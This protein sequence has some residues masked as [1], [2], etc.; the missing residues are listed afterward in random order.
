MINKKFSF[1]LGCKFKAD[2]I[3]KE[4]FNK[5][6]NGLTGNLDKLFYPFNTNCWEK[7]S[8]T[9]GGLEGWW[10]YEQYAYWLDGYVKCAYFSNNKK[11][12]KKAKTLIDNALKVVSDNGF[13]GAKEL[14][15]QG[16]GNQWVHAVFFRAVLFLY[17]ITKDK[18]Y[19]NK[20]TNHYLSNTNDYSNWR[21]TV[22]VENMINCFA[23]TGDERLLNLAISAYEKHSL[24]ES[25]I[26]TK[27]SDFNKTSPIKL[28]AVTYNEI[29]KIPILLYSATGDE[30]YLN[31][32]LNGLKRI[33]DNH[34][35]PI[36]IHSGA[37]SF[38]GTSSLSAVET[39]DITDHCLTLYTVAKITG[40]TKYLD[41]I[42]RIMYNVAPS[43]MD[44]DFKTLQYFSSMNQV[45][46]TH[47][48]NHTG[49][50]T[51]TPRMS[52][53]SDH[54]PECCAGNAN[55]SMPNFF[56]Q[57]VNKTS[58][59]V[60][61]N[62][63]LPGSYKFDGHE[64]IIKTNYP[65]S[66]RVEITYRGKGFNG[67]V[68]LRKPAWCKKFL[69]NDLESVATNGWAQISLLSNGDSFTVDIIS[70]LEVKDVNEGY[71][72]VKEP[73]VYTLKID[74]NVEIDPVETRVKEGYPA[75]DVT[76][77]SSWQIAL[78]KRVFEKNA[79]LILGKNNN[80]LEGDTVVT[81][82]VFL[83]KGVGL[84]KTH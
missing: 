16:E 31:A 81:S 57:A 52:Y 76:P 49:S 47:Y 27:L 58:D 18:T 21:E 3:I 60:A 56:Y 36:G 26:E 46:S 25:N 6:L 33:D 50:F 43:V 53:Q 34:L 8:F 79:K 78:D 19:L 32:T 59:G 69:I 82:K 10:P 28:H 40:D 14:Q 51:F 23:Y 39:C 80:L 55:R 5:M 48:S 15:K 29:V 41:R 30:K 67:V 77:N 84:Y 54:Y 42:E 72:V 70:D 63:Y 75:Y 20:I 68:S 13:I 22:N 9:D 62:F 1:P 12:F 2:G 66:E 4:Y 35:L 17:E 24:N 7:Q 83:M 74:A 38:G 37:E 45:I 44:K 65:F 64:F 73:L 61:F 11:H 71:M